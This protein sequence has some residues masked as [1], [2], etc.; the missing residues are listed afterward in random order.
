[1]L[2]QCLQF[3]IFSPFQT[4]KHVGFSRYIALICT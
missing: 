2:F 4:L 3:K 1:M